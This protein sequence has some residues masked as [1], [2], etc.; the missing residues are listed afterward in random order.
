MA[1][2]IRGDNW[3]M[4]DKDRPVQAAKEVVQLMLDEARKLL[5]QAS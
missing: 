4:F 2:L 1:A 5:D 3:I